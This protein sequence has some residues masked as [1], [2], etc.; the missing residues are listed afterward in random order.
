VGENGPLPLGAP[1]QRALLAALLLRGNEVVARETLVDLLWGADPPRSA[2]QSLQVYVHGLRQALGADRIET[3][4]TSYRLTL[5]PDEL[6][7][8]RFG[9]LV[10]E[11]SRALDAGQAADASEHLTA[12]LALWRGAAL[13]DL[14]GEPVAASEA[15]QLEERRLRAREL[16]NDAELALGR[17]EALVPEL[18]QLIAAEPYR[19]R[20]RAQHVLS[21]YRAGRQKEALEA[22]RAARDA[23]VEELGVDPSP[24][25]QELERAILRQDPSLA[26]PEPPTAPR[27]KLPTPPTALIG[28]GLEV[29]AVIALLQSEGVRLLT[30]TGPG[31]T[32]KTR[33]ALAVAEELGPQLRDGAVFVDLAPLRDASLLAPTIAHALEIAEGASA[34]ESLQEHLAKRRLL[35]VLDN[36]EQLAPNTEVVA[37]LVA[38]APRL[39]VLATSRT[40]LRLAAE[41][42]Y[43]VPPLAV[44]QSELASF[45]Q[46]AANDAVRLFASRARAVDHAFELDDTTAGAVAHICERLDGLPLAIELAAARSKLF[47]PQAMS[48]RL[49][50]SLELL[51]GG[52]HDVP[53]RQRTLRSTLEW[54]YELLDDDERTVFA[55]LSVF[56]G[57][58]T[59]DAGTAVCGDDAIDVVEALARLV[60]DNLVRRLQR[61]RE[62]RFAMLETIAEFARERLAETGEADAVRRR[63]AEYVLSLAVEGGPQLLAADPETF[64]RFD[65]DLEN[66]RAA[67][68]WFAATGEVTSEVRILDA[69]WNFLNVRGHL[70]EGRDLLEA[71][72][73]RGADAPAETRALALAHC[74]TFA[75]RQGDYA[76]GKQVTEEAL[77]LFRE[78]G[79][80]NQVGRCI[81]TLGNMA[82]GEGDLDRAIELYE[83]AAVLT[84]EVGNRSR[85][86][87]ILA[88]LGSIAGQRNEAEQ[89][90]RYASEAV[91]LQR[92]LGE[93]DSL[94][95]SLHNLGRAE[96]A[97][98]HVD[99][100]AAALAESLELAR[101]LGYREVIAYGFS[102]LA[103]LALLEKRSERA[104]E[105]LGASEDL[106]RELGVGI[107]QGEAKAQERMLTALHATLGEARTDELRAR[108]AAR[109]VDELVNA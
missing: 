108:G 102:G 94:A 14:G 53:A 42:E 88:N 65:E 99:A 104:A 79:D 37:R 8:A 29:A 72:I 31:G 34:E 5:E 106:F 23:L 62:P 44:P 105:L 50:R 75:F 18:E 51:T 98:G 2:V 28:R 101:E 35:L 68:H 67:L 71:A 81:G 56:A 21:L 90:A 97:Q 24:E 70:S 11:G 49:D 13:A 77:A 55:R 74:G 80:A 9:R 32:G 33:L 69:L 93:V 27:V 39:L 85:L 4:G 59:L 82:V 47:P 78:L 91:A 103:E 73:G 61:G 52:P 16:L 15:P 6:D 41:H 20:F 7:V 87:L 19:E 76:R 26:A 92:E 3:H 46:L 96:L 40:P 63:H 86:A 48:S 43:P 84:R 1:K 30:L 64:A 38:A 12:A 109:P 10:A 89:S 57:G 54:S 36:L 83:E 17:H 66:V 100:A 60:D 45:E 95:V 22:Y 58:W 107:E 25:L